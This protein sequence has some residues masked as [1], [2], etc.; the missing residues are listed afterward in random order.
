MLHAKS[1]LSFPGECYCCGNIATVTASILDTE[2]TITGGAIFT[3]PVEWNCPDAYLVKCQTCWEK[4]P[5]FY[6]KTEVYSR[7]VGYYRPISQWNNG[8]QAE[9]AQRENFDFPV[10]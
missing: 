5:F 3:P 7:V 6:P 4:D 1:P 10:L 8:K 9:F 2:I